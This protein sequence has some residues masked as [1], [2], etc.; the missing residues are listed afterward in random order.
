[1]SGTCARAPC[2]MGSEH[3]CVTPLSSRRKME[4]AAPSPFLAGHCP[5]APTSL[6]SWGASAYMEPCVDGLWPCPLSPQARRACCGSWVSPAP[7]MSSRS[8]A[9]AEGGFQ[10]RGCGWFPVPGLRVVSGS[11]AA[12][13]A[14]MFCLPRACAERGRTAWPPGR[15]DTRLWR[16]R[17]SFHRLVPAPTSSCSRGWA[18]V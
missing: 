16:C 8:L 7:L 3:I 14:C 10:F 13:G 6:A 5:P 2:T 9:G 11:G 1:M 12:R 17:A 18:R 4:P 15:C